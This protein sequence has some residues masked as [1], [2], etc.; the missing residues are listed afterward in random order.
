MLFKNINNTQS[1][2]MKLPRGWITIPPGETAD[3]PGL[4]G[5]RHPN[6][7]PVIVDGD[8]N[9]DGVFDKKDVSKAAKTLVKGRKKT[10]KKKAT[11]KK[12][13]WLSKK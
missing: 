7:R 2:N 9:N 6:L 12:K 8:L 10:T 11:K 1:V 13:S 3:V 5:Q 4:A